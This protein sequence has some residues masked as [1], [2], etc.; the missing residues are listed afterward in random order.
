MAGGSTSSAF[1]EDRPNGPAVARVLDEAVERD[2]LTVL[3][4]RQRAAPMRVV[5]ER[6]E[7]VIARREVVRKGAARGWPASRVPSLVDRPPW[8]RRPVGGL[9]KG[10]VKPFWP[11]CHPQPLS[12]AAQPPVAVFVAT[13]LI[14]V[15]V[16][17]GACQVHLPSKPSFL[18]A[19]P[20]LDFAR[21]SVRSEI[22]AAQP[23]TRS[24]SRAQDALRV[25]PRE[26]QEPRPPPTALHPRARRRRGAHGRCSRLPRRPR[27]GPC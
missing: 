10:S 22:P 2:P 12:K 19:T 21:R 5:D 4:V 15:D 7:A 24:C 16:P 18:L 11:G 25:R 20:S 17:L 3:V 27:S 6:D 9:G 8:R 1:G 23:A 26:R 14:L 13:V